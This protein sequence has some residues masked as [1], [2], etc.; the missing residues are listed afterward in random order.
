M[1]EHARKPSGVFH[2]L[3]GGGLQRPRIIHRNCPEFLEGYREQ[4]KDKDDRFPLF[5]VMSYCSP[6]ALLLLQSGGL[7]L[8]VPCNPVSRTGMVLRLEVGS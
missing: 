6:N 3:T 8:D 5:E 1:Q 7:P 4:G 2:L